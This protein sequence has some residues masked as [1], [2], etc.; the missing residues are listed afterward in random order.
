MFFETT[1]DITD[2]LSMLFLVVVF[3]SVCTGAFKPAIAT[4]AAS[5]PQN[6]FFK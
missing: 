1:L 4:P 2:I 3:A 5:A 6:A